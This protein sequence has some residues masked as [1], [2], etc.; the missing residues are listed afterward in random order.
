[1]LKRLA[2]AALAGGLTLFV[3]PQLAFAHGGGG[4]GGGQSRSGGGHS[5]H[6][7]AG[8][9]SAPSRSGGHDRHD[10]SYRDGYY[11]PGY[12]GH[13]GSYYGGYNNGY[14]GDGRYYYGRGYCAGGSYGDSPR[15]EGTWDC[16]SDPDR[17][18]N[19]YRQPC[20]YYSECTNYPRCKD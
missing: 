14:C 8:G 20:R 10:H 18:H 12:G 6:A 3:G 7:D 2:V 9:R 15:D 16:R 4:G 11:Y 13:D 19:R 5:S 1:M 17:D